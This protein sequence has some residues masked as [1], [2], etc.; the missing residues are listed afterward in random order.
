MAASQRQVEFA[1]VLRQL[2]AWTAQAMWEARVHGTQLTEIAITQHLLT[3]IQQNLT[4][5]QVSQP[6]E[7]Q[8]GA[9][10]VWT[11]QRAPGQQT[12][13]ICQ[14]K[15]LDIDK[16]TYPQL[17]HR[18]GGHGGQQQVDILLNYAAQQNAE[19]FYVLYNYTLY[20]ERLTEVDNKN[21]GCFIVRAADMKGQI[22]NYNASQV[23]GDT[24]LTWQEI[25][26]L[27]VPW[28][29]LATFA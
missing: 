3:A 20:D 1:G 9:D 27:A 16:G 12:K 6:N 10:W 4:F 22:D 2:S 19:A 17:N 26:Q 7:S 8:T 14:A 29:H 11:I 25:K 21:N 24:S 18:V 23:I 5:I 15:I 28:S 13:I